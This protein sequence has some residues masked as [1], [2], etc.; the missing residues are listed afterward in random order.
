[1]AKSCFVCGSAESKYKCPKCRSGYCSVSCYKAHKDSAACAE[2]RQALSSEKKGEE[3]AAAL[4]LRKLGERPDEGEEGYRITPE[5]L[6]LMVESKRLRDLLRD[7]RLR[8][9]IELVDGA[10]DREKALDCAVE[11]NKDFSDF[12]RALAETINPQGAPL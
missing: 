2:A 6:D 3:S 8:E 5:Q 4:L 11:T 9:V 10:E 7:P 12:V 1:M